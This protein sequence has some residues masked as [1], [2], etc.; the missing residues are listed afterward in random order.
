MRSSTH[1]GAGNRRVFDPFAGFHSVG[2]AS[3]RNHYEN[4][5]PHWRQYVYCGNTVGDGVTK[6]NP[7]IGFGDKQPL[8]SRS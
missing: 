8:Q 2:Q 1:V 5:A 4:W 3:L 6:L 7:V